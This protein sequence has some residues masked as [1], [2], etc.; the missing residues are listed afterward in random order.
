MDPASAIAVAS[1]AFGAIKAGFAAGRE[2]ETM[3]KDIM[4]W[5][6]AIQDIKKGHENEKKRKSRFATIEEE[7]LETWI[8]KKRAEEME[9]ELRTFINFNYGPNSWN[10]LLRVQAQIR[11]ERQREKELREKQIKQGIEIALATLMVCVIIGSLVLGYNLVLD[12][13]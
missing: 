8:I 5:M 6:G 3:T 10:E 2:V 12:H 7:A 11:K 1:S 13:M 4:R 9:N